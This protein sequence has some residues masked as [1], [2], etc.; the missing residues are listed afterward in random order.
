MTK[1]EE[2]FNRFRANTI[3]Y[4]LKH[5][6]V[7]GEKPLVYADW[8]ASGR[9]YAPIEKKLSEHIGQFVANTHTE[10]STTGTLM[11]EAYH[12]ARKIIKKHV[13]A[14]ES[15]VLL[16]PG[17]G[18]TAAIVK[19]QRIIG[20]KVCGKISG[21]DCL[22]KSERPVVFITHMEHHS[23]HTSWYE[24]IADVE[25]IK[26]DKN[27]LVDPENLRETI[28]KYKN[29]KIKIGS[30]TACSNVT[31]IHTPYYELAKIMHQYG[32]VCFV[33]FA[34]NAPYETIN[35]H[36]EDPEMALDAIFFSPHKFLG[37]PGSSGVLIFNKKLYNSKSPDQP[38]GGT[39]EWTNPWGEYEYHKDIE[40]REDGGT[41]GF[42]QA[43]RTALCILL[44]EEMNPQ[45]IMQR[46]IELLEIAFSGLEKIPN[47]VILAGETK[48]RLGAI[49]FYINNLHY[50]LCVK[51]L[52]DMYGIQVRGGCACAGT[53]GHYLLD[54]T[55]EKS[56]LITSKINEGD[57]SEKPGWVRLSLHPT[58]TDSELNYIIDALKDIAE[59]HKIYSKDYIYDKHKNEFY[60]KNNIQYHKEFVNN[61]FSR[62][63]F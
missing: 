42:M 10:S 1:L 5:K 31:G 25:I 51:L 27:L 38:G 14:N 50:N 21:R 37:G 43:I 39:V 53:Y 58:M 61:I 47:L 36:P 48:Q 35:M 59:N 18:M 54:V 56:H 9:L 7:Y 46:E 30:F 23:N 22:D 60:H 6:T 19:L 8:I 2:Y 4:N 40:A 24:T 15:D 26:P 11:T 55:H 34:A 33:D 45:L 20:L 17:F 28:Q 29:R 52:S 13:N 32:G 49:S 12:T 62:E 16:T 44:K 3:G 57:L 63:T 41:P